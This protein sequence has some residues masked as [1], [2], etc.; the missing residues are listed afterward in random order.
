[1]ARKFLIESMILLV[2]PE[3]T[4]D[5]VG[6]R[7]FPWKRLHL[8]HASKLK[9]LGGKIVAPRFFTEFPSEEREKMDTLEW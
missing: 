3:A 1:M 5:R 7:R 6:I 9:S 4:V 8:V 2:H